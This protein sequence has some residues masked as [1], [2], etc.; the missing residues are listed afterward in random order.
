MKAEAGWEPSLMPAIKGN[1]T[2]GCCGAKCTARW[3]IE[4]NTTELMQ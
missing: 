1:T 3:H 4:H 2:R